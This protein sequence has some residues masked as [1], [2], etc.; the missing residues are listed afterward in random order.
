MDNTFLLLHS[1]SAEPTTQP[2]QISSLAPNK[3]SKFP[4]STPI[5]SPSKLP[6]KAPS[7]SPAFRPTQRPTDPPASRS[8]TYSPSRWPST[9]PSPSFR[10]S[11]SPSFSPASQTSSAP[12]SPPTLFIGFW[13]WTWS[14][15]STSAPLATTAS[16]AF[17]GYADP[18]TAISAST[19][20]KSSLSG[21]KFISFG[22]GIAS[23]GSFTS[24]TLSK[25]TTAISNGALAGYSGICYDIEEGDAGLQSAFSLSF[26][27]AKSN[28]LKVLVTV[29]HSQPYAVTDAASLMLALLADNNIDYISPQLYTTGYESA[30]DYTAVGTTWSQYASSK[31]KVVPSI[32]S[33]CLFP[34]AQAYFKTYGVTLSGYI[35]WSQTTPSC[36]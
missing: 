24:S 19:A 15:A 21:I 13:W 14:P 17:S 4:S 30:N 18:S 8:P 32:V 35:Q 20:L 25:I 6:S 36:T 7:S 12:P 23:S 31:A 10:P 1:P 2:I 11:P 33:S 29:S 22:G 26:A 28:G 9:T 16:I 34:S 5:G 27:T 3:I